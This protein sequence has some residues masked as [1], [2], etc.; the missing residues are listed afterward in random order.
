MNR[1]FVRFTGHTPAQLVRG[2]ASQDAAFWAFSFNGG[3]IGKLFLPADELNVV[4]VQD[5]ILA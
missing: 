1:D 4:S 5:Q 3:E 2:I